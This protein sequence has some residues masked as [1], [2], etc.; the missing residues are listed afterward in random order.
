VAQTTKSASFDPTANTLA[1]SMVLANELISR[2]QQPR[3]FKQQ[4]GDARDVAGAYA[5][6]RDLLL[7]LA[8]A[9]HLSLAAPPAASL[10][11]IRRKLCAARSHL[12]KARVG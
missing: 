4:Y 10:R 7:I 1:Y 3:W 2:G 5:L 9:L 6:P 11:S 12:E 8:L